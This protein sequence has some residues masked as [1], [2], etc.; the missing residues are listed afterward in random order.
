MTTGRPLQSQLIDT[1]Q[2]VRKGGTP[3]RATRSP[4]MRGGT[5]PPRKRDLPPVLDD[6]RA[7]SVD[8]AYKRKGTPDEHAS[9]RKHA[10]NNTNA[11]N[12]S[13][14]N[15]G[16]NSTWNHKYKIDKKTFENKAFNGNS[17]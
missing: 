16:N 12:L 9:E 3:P 6:D 14:F 7:D 17:F 8:R 1:S 2:R 5:P 4:P 11:P 10:S 13:E 15:R